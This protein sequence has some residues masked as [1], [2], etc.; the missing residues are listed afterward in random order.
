[1]KDNVNLRDLKLLG[2]NFKE[3][4]MEYESPDNSY[5]IYSVKEPE[6]AKF[7]FIVL[8]FHTSDSNNGDDWNETTIVDELFSGVG[9]FDGVRH[10]KLNSY[11]N[12]P[13]F[14]YM[15]KIFLVISEI[16]KEICDI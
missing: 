16:E 8:S 7:E 5:R 9:I 2:K 12:Y 1:M 11:I 4:I 14:E 13:S 3:W 10:L 6:N 15:S